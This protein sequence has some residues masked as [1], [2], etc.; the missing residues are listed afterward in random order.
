MLGTMPTAADASTMAERQQATPPAWLG[1]SRWKLAADVVGG[2][3]QNRDKVVQLAGF[4]HGLVSPALVRARLERMRQL[5]HCDVVPTVAQLLLAARDQL[6]FGLAEDTKEF[7][8]SQGIPWTFHNLRRVVA[9]PSTMMDPVGLFSPRDTIIHHVLQTFHRHPLY[10]LL[11]LRAYDGGLEEMEAQVVQLLEGTHP[12][13]RSLTSLIEDGS[14][15]RRLLDDVREVMDNPHVEP[16][17]IPE[18]LVDDP[19][20]M[21]AMDQFKDLR[22]YT[23]YA[24]RLD[25]TAAGA[26]A[27]YLPVA[28]NETIGGPL[29]MKLGQRQL[30]V[31]CCD[32]E[33]RARHGL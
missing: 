14:Y 11:L 9:F 13:Q 6:S 24:S 25:V 15:H 30:R 1:R 28:F 27:A 21:L 16:R 31:E 10:D 5:G 22:G 12:H 4:F 18:G 3:R 17:P 2:L 7:Y 32:P 19:H 33:L 29:G 20:L 8:E 23:N 26:L